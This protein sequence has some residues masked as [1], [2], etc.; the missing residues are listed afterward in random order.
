[1]SKIESIYDIFFQDKRFNK[2]EYVMRLERI[3]KEILRLFRNG[4]ISDAHYTILDKKTTDYISLG[5][6]DTDHE[7]SD[8]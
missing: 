6:I 1:L 7:K 5:L 2:E 3:R 8:S 4:K